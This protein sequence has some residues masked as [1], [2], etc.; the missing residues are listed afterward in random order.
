MQ[1]KSFSYKKDYPRLIKRVP[2]IVKPGGAVL[3]CLNAPDCSGGE[4]LE[5]IAENLPGRFESITAVP[6]PDAYLGRYPERG[7]K[8]YLAEAYVK[9]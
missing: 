8:T 6:C 1:G 2:E 4:F 3:F 5:M 9:D 7:L